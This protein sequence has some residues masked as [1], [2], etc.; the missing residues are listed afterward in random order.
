VIGAL[1]L[2][3]APNCVLRIPAMTP[4]DQ[5]ALFRAIASDA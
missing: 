2:L 1:V 3:R 4:L 5:L